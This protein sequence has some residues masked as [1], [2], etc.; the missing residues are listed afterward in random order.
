V[1][2]GT[3]LL[4]KRGKAANAARYVSVVTQRRSLDL[5]ASSEQE[6]A[7]V[8]DGL[9]AVFF[10]P[11]A[12]VGALSVLFPGA[13]GEEGEEEEEVEGEGEAGLHPEDGDLDG[14]VEGPRGGRGAGE[15]GREEEE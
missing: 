2:Q 15:A 11:G 3:P 7:W 14:D 4:I 12:L 5:E 8:A 10:Q 6:R 13:V 1:G 9:R